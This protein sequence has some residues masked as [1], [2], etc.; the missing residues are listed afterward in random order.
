MSRSPKSN[1]S[2]LEMPADGSWIMY[3]NG[4]G[5]PCTANAS[6]IISANQKTGIAWPKNA[7]VVIT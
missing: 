7:N 5:I 3:P 1:V 2:L 6:C 4:N